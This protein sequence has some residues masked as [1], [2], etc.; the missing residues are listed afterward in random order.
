MNSI[1]SRLYSRCRRFGS[2]IAYGDII[3]YGFDMSVADLRAWLRGGAI[4]IPD[5]HILGYVVKFV[6]TDAYPSWRGR[7]NGPRLFRWN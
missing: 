7:G 6:A 3:T 2:E 5:R 1:A 4:E